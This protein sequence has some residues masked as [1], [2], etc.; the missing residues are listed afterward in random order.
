MQ[1]N[2][3][4]RFI[5]VRADVSDQLSEALPL[6]PLYISNPVCCLFQAYATKGKQLSA[7]EESLSLMIQ[8]SRFQ[9][10]LL[11]AFVNLCSIQVPQATQEKHVLPRIRRYGDGG[12][13]GD[14][15][16]GNEEIPG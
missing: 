3:P 13:G 4:F 5:E 2:D 6:H 10:F 12:A 14:D 8:N 9:I 15:G 1:E 16:N 11:P 7:E